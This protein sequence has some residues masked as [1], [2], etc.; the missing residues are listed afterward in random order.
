[1]AELINKVAQ[2]GLITIDPARFL[3][4]IKIVPFDLKGFLFKELILREKEFR[5]ELIE[6]DW[7]EF[8]NAVVA[9]YCSSDAI[10]PMWAYMLAASY[11]IPGS[12][13]VIWGN[14][15]EA[16]IEFVSLQIAG[17]DIEPYIGKRVVIKGCGDKEIHPRLYM[18]LTKK[19]QPV[20]KSLMFGEPCS[21]V[22]IYKNREL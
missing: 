4:G 19:L 7:K 20:V 6:K 14:V 18:E 21:T 3:E 10:I 17:M 5:K 12:T 11:L 16:E 13:N 8:D 1:L 9:L 22:P 15:N 2:S